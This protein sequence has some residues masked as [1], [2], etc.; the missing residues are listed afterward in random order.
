MTNGVKTSRWEK[1][2]PEMTANMLTF[3]TGPRACV[4]QK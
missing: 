1:P 3:S 2:T 4:G